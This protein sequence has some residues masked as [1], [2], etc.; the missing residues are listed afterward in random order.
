MNRHWKHIITAASFSLGINII[1]F[2]NSATPASYDVSRL[3][4]ILMWLATPAEAFTE[5]IIPGHVS[6][7]QL[8]VMFA[9]SLIFYTIAVYVVLEIWTLLRNCLSQSDHPKD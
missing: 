1:F 8:I 5:W 9:F 3:N 6:L 7:K 4:R 2:V